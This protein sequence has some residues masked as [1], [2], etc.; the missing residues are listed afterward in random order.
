MPLCI[1]L[2]NAGID[3]NAYKIKFTVC[4]IE[5][6]QNWLECQNETFIFVSGHVEGFLTSVSQAIY[7]DFFWVFL[8]LE[9]LE[10]SLGS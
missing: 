2:L 6:N 5:T 10:N 8:L 1:D 3:K 9:L 7:T 4:E